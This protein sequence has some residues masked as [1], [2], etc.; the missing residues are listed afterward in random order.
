MSDFRFTRPDNFPPI[1][2]NLI[3][4]NVLVWICQIIFDRQGYN[5]TGKLALYPFNSDV[6]KPYQIAT[7]MFAHSAYSMG[8]NIVFFHILFNMF[9]LWMFG[10]VL[11]NVWGPKRFLFFYL[12][13][14][15]GAAVAHLAVQYF[16]GGY[17]AAVG[18][19][20]AI[21]GILVGFAY[22][23]P[24]TELFIMFIP[25]PIKAKWAVIGYVVI[26]LFFGIGNFSGDNI[27]HFAH[28]GGAITG[29]ILVLIWNKTEP[30]RF[31]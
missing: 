3:I 13:C 4:I 25:F 22:L 10:K 24:N 6:F 30:K 8:G 20:G 7:H 12:A 28:L 23:F 16:T 17:S 21:M 1:T 14:G 15:V 31:Y 5:L 27:A 11:E 18:A 26:D 2:K 29:F 19:S 9:A